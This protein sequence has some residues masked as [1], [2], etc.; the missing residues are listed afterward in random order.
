[1]YSSMLLNVLVLVNVLN[2]GRDFT[3]R[4]NNSQR[5]IKSCCFNDVFPRAFKIL[6]KPLMYFPKARWNQYSR[7]LEHAENRFQR[8]LNVTQQLY[9]LVLYC[10]KT[11]FVNF[12]M[13]KA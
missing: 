4:W 9:I 11:F 10:A 1:M 8:A 13:V 12:E 7:I 6:N 5:A 3:A 2:H